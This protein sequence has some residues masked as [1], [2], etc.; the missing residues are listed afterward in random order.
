MNAGQTCVAP[1]Y[2]FLPDNMVDA[3]VNL[4]RTL[5]AERYPD[6]NDE[7]YTSVI[8]AK[9]FTRLREALDDAV[10]KGATAINLTGN[11]FNPELRKFPP[12]VVINVS[13]DMVIMQEEIF[14][15]ILPVLTYS[16]ID[17]VLNYINDRDRPLGLYVF[18]NDK[19]IQERL[20]YET[21]SGGVTINHCA[22]HVFQHDLPF[23]GV[24]ASGMG[25]YHGHEGFLELS[26]LRPV[27]TFPK[28]GKPD[29]FY[30]PYT[31]AHETLFNLLNKLKL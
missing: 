31:R 4:A 14:G 24:G 7:A 1:D 16:S 11:D 9:S 12:H 23:G 19:T 2:L 6:T 25:Q 10:A 17:Q 5:V 22:F 18:T 20:L 30:P 13:N 28:L 27:F 29:L 21:M 26:K 3:F 15:P 8:D